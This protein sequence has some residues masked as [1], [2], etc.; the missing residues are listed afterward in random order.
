M[1]TVGASHV[2]V[3]P[4]GGYAEHSPNE[5]TPV[6]R[7]LNDNDISA[8]VFR[9]SNAIPFRC[10]RSVPRLLSDATQARRRSGSWDSQ[11]AATWLVWRLWRPESRA[12]WQLALDTVASL[13]AE[14]VI[15]GHR[16]PD[17]A[18]DDAGRQIDDSRRYLGAFDEPLQNSD[19]A[20]ELIR[21]MTMPT[22]TSEIPTRCG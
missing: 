18:D 11:Q 12:N 1:P 22:P 14:T 17:A 8:S 4:G 21:R 7:W 9:C 10:R 6:A 15:A 2:I 13:G 3:L 20:E 19:S 5:S 16:N